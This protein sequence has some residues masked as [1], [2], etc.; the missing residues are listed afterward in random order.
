MIK[1]IADEN[2]AY[3]REAFSLL[4]DVTL[5]HGRKITPDTLKDADVLIVRSITM[6]NENLLAGSRIKFVGTATI[7]KDHVD[8]EYLDRN[9]I[10]FA[11]AA[12]CNA[13]AVKEYVFTALT[14]VLVKRNLQFKDLSAGIIGV[15]NVGSK[16]AKCAG[17]LGMRTILNDPPLKR[18]TGNEIFREL[19]EALKADIV[20]LHVPLNK[21]G[22]DRTYHLLD[23]DNLNRLKE[24]TIL[25]NSS[26]GSVVDRNALKKAIDEK[27]LTVILDVWENEPDIDPV[28]LQKVFIGTPHIAGYSFEGKINGTMMMYSALCRFLKRKEIF[29][30]PKPE[31]NN[32]I[33]EINDPHSIEESLQKIF[34]RIYDIGKDDF[35]LRRILNDKQDETGRY[36][37]QLRKDYHLRYEFANY[38][39]VVPEDQEELIKILTALGFIVRINR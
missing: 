27:N 4:G 23:A 17:A 14:E 35:N 28:L 39:I 30:P 20:T 16:V 26:R 15:G 19:D 34:R 9:N 1:I 22:I 11:D 8:V 2:I 7:G 37:D 25:I 6:V 24:D 10:A 21:E 32:S 36:F 31:I 33:L 18:K 12:G 3:A 38:T 5:L 13:N 29:S